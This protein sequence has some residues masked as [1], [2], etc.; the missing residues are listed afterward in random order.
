MDISEVRFDSQDFKMCPRVAWTIELTRIS[1]VEA[2]FNLVLKFVME[3][4]QTLRAFQSTICV[5]EPMNCIVT[6]AQDKHE[7][8]GNRNVGILRR[9][10]QVAHWHAVHMTRGPGGSVS[11]SSPHWARD[12]ARNAIPLQR[13]TSFA[14][15]IVKQVGTYL[16]QI[17]VNLSWFRLRVRPDQQLQYL[18]A[19]CC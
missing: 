1:S 11:V 17:K 4:R 9:N 8:I 7:D 14:V 3:S 16:K 5:K 15:P 13:L 18:Q 6:P 19:C 12:W 2:M 10:S